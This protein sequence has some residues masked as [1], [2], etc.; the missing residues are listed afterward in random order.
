[1][2]PVHH[3]PTHEEVTLH[4]DRSA[5]L[6]VERGV[7][8]HLS[9]PSGDH[10]VLERSAEARS[11]AVGE[12]LVR[13]DEVDQED[14][15]IQAIAVEVVRRVLRHLEVKVDL[16]LRGTSVDESRSAIRERPREAE[17]EVELPLSGIL[18]G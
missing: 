1:M 14:T 7:D 3:S 6:V 5:V 8:A 18:L 4:P 16:T 11:V 2:G 17:N 10:L 13:L 12:D 9:L 15:D